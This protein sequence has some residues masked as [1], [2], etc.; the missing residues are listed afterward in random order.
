MLTSHSDVGRT[1]SKASAGS[2]DMTN[3]VCTT[4]CFDQGYAYAGTEWHRECF[5]GQKLAAGGVKAEDQDDCNTPCAGNQT[6]ACG[7]SNRLTLYK[8][9]GPV[10]NPGFGDWEARGCY[11]YVSVFVFASVRE[12]ADEQ[13]LARRKDAAARA[14]A[15]GRLDDGCQVRQRVRCS[16]LSLCWR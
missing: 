9:K 1:I 5:C 6:Q 11:S 3:E 13:G 15:A 16:G 14:G 8:A 4:F 7:G 12:V 10:Q 2:D